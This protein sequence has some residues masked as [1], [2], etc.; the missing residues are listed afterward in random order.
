MSGVH[1]ADVPLA[2]AR[3]LVRRA[4]DK[5][6]QLGLR[7][8]IAVVGASGALVTASRLDHGGPGGMARA[9]SKAWISA[10]Q[11][12]PSSEHLQR[13]T[14]LPVPIS[15]GFVTASPEALFPGAGGLPIRDA[16]GTVI[17]G[18]SA[19]G[20]TVSPF[21][22]AGV[23]PEVVSADGKPAN[24]EDLLIAY[25]MGTPYV[26]QHGD[27]EARWK[28]RFGDLVVSP[29][30]S[31]GMKPASPAAA[32]GELD[33]ALALVDRVL[34]EAARQGLTISVAVVDRGGDPIQQD[35]MDGAVAGGVEVALATASA[36]A[37]FGIPSE[38]LAAWYPAD[39]LAALH[40]APL[41]AAPG[42]LPIELDGQVV[43]G[44]GIGG[45]QPARCAALARDAL[46]LAPSLPVPTSPAWPS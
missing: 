43:A 12:I 39:Q 18:I 31:L 28:A 1:P 37:R 42:G 24:P 33:W 17:G 2:Q 14:T 16:G 23:A 35:R 45:A 44:L 34:A 4:V 32:Q 5:A 46:T 41:L 30:A 25:A 8:A 20:A 11:Q 27:D 38:H 9:R 22:P 7:G 40:P 10:T 36:A 29:E 15:T 13:M 26:G 21:L 6:E 3:A 19:S